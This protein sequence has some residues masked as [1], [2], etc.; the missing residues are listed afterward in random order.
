MRAASNAARD[1]MAARA[2]DLLSVE[3]FHVVFTLPAQ[4]ARTTY[5]KKRAVYG[6][7]FKASA[8]TVVT[9]AADPKHLG[10]RIGVTSILHTWGQR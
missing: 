2:E 8:Q 1:W 5:S 6:R 10:A 4:I 3:Y 9:I 7:L